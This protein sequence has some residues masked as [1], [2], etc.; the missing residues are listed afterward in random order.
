MTG[1]YWSFLRLHLSTIFYCLVNILLIILS[2]F[3]FCVKMKPR[4]YYSTEVVVQRCSVKKGVPRKSGK[5][6]RKH[7]W[8]SLFLIKLQTACRFIT[9]ETSAQVFSCKICK[10]FKNNYFEELE[11]LD[12]L[13]EYNI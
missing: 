10:I 2:N 8:Q 3:L 12:G 6:T 9:K 11:E 1:N 7:L 4:Y 5:F 13:E